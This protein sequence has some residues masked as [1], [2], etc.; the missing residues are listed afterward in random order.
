LLI[1]ANHTKEKN[2]NP[3]HD[4]ITISHKEKKKNAMVVRG[5]K[6]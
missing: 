2:P 3:K 5:E 6:I 1:R 4:N